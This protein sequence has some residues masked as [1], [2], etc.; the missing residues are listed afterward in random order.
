MELDSTDPGSVL[1]DI[2]HIFAHCVKF[3]KY[4]H[5]SQYILGRNTGQEHWAGTLGRN[6]GQEHTPDE[7]PV[8]FNKIY[9]SKWFVKQDL[10]T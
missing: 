9:K 3:K 1:W 7:T 5:Y 4:I 10:P 6:T 8:L 2:W